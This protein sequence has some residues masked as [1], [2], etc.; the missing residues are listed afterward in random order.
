MQKVSYYCNV[1]KI[2]YCF[3]RNTIKK[4]IYCI[5]VN[6]M[7]LICLIVI[8]DNVTQCLKSHTPVI[9]KKKILLL[10]AIQ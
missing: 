8:K 1:K 2:Y 5:N 10:P 6:L 7:S 9:W 4:I 3:F